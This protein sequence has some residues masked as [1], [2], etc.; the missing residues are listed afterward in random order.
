VSGTSAEQDWQT[1]G[2]RLK[3]VR[4]YLD[5][6]QQVVASRTGIPRSAISDVERGQRKLDSLELRKLA[7]LYGY[8]VSFFLEDET[9][10]TDTVTALARAVDDLT[11]EDRD[12][13]IRFAQYLRYNSRAKKRSS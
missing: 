7:R 13:I 10:P 5:L 11:A 8:P 1:L 2:R 9:P 6:S 4:E 3:E 12:E